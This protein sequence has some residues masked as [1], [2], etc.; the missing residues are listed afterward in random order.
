MQQ[1]QRRACKRLLHTILVFI[2]LILPVF[3]KCLATMSGA[4]GQA[5][6][7]NHFRSVQELI[8]E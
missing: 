7:L 3:K 5:S 6:A 1:P 4:L 8:Q 2:R